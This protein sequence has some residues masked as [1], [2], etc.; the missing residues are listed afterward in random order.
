MQNMIIFGH[1]VSV[2]KTRYTNSNRPAVQLI[3]E[4]EGCPFCMLSV[5]MSAELGDEEFVVK[6]WSENEEVAV[7]ALA[8]GLFVDTG[9]KVQVGFVEAPI[10][11]FA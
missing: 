10:W 2:H 5:N 6:D 1:E 9:R 8:S 3:D 7:A 11:R 4:T